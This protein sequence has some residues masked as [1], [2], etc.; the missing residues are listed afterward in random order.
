MIEVKFIEYI[1]LFNKEILLVF[2]NIYYLFIKEKV[3]VE[4]YFCQ[5]MGNGFVNICMF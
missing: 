1:Y 4:V 2:Q 3:L 5:I